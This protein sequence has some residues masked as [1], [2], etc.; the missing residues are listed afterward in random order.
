[1]W[2]FS[3]FAVKKKLCKFPL[4]FVKCHSSGVLFNCNE[5]EVNEELVSLY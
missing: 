5:M 3:A 4:E 1:M 2:D